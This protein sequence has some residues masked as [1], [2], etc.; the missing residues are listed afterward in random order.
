[1]RAC[2]RRLAPL[3]LC[4]LL[5]TG[6]MAAPP[7]GVVRDE[8]AGTDAL[9]SA[10]T[11]GL[12]ADSFK[13]G[14][15]FRLGDTGYLA[16]EERVI[17]VPPDENPEK[18]VVQ[19]LLDGPAALSS[20]LSPLFPEGT[21]VMAVSRQEDILYITFNEALLGRYGDEPGDLSQEPWKTESPLRRRLCMASLTATLT[22]A[23][24]CAGVQVLVFREQVQQ[25]S[26]RLQAGYFDLS[27]DDT[28]LPALTRDE[29]VLLTPHNAAQ[30]IL[31][32]W[33]TRDWETLYLMTAA[34]GE[35]GAREGEAAALEAFDAARAL[36]GFVL[37]PGSVSLDGGTATVGA[38]LTL[39]SQGGDEAVT[40]YPIRLIREKGIWK[41]P[42]ERLLALMQRE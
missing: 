36:T 6:C 24:L 10:D 22:E 3:F 18:A 27:G 26:M 29:S 4:S 13:A 34:Q 5:L 31:N 19:A 21:E 12:R 39:L 14:L 40:G 23:G 11:D 1:M 20:S 35:N 42:Y 7:A 8:P 38:D 37:T 9:I 2:L 41:I 28:L 17:S 32:A 16:A 33:M 25:N 30:A 15:Y